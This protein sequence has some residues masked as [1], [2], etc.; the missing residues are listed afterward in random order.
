MTDLATA[1]RAVH[2]RLAAT[3]ELPLDRDA[4]RW[5]AEAEAVAGDLRDV[6]DEAVIR[7]R[8]GH[9]RELLSNVDATGHPEADDHVAAAMELADEIA[10]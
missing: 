10:D 5:I 3:E 4:T 8:M 7:E 6:D 1:V 9:V 2:D